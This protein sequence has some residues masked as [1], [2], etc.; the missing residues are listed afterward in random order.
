MQ[1]NSCFQ[2]IIAVIPA[3][4][5]QEMVGSVVSSVL[6]VVDEVIVVDD[7]SQDGTAQSAAAA[8]AFVLRHMLNRGQGAALQTGTEAALARGADVVVH[9]DADGQMEPQ[10]IPQALFVL[11]ESGADVVLGTRF[12]KESFQKIPRAKRI[13]LK[14]ARVFQSFVLNI[15]FSDTHCGFRAL[16]RKAAL[17]MAL[18]HSRMDH[19]T[20]I[21][22][23][24]SKSKFR[25]ME[26]PVRVYYTPYARAKSLPFF[27]HA[28]E[29]LKG[30]VV[31]KFLK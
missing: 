23:W 11:E 1:N 27:A 31:G 17:S 9:F 21:G 6:P 16:S 20:E 18:Q 12:S 8:G 2:K 29:V 10:D 14:T 22:E 15:P 28:W 26:M 4:E 25:V 3:F 19:A 30:V 13:I 7:G 24:L 5:E